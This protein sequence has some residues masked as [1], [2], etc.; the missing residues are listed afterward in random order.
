M[1]DASAFGEH[2]VA[3]QVGGVEDTCQPHEAR[4]DSSNT[5]SWTSQEAQDKGDKVEDRGTRI[6]EG[7]IESNAPLSTVG[8]AP[9]GQA[10]HNRTQRSEE[11][12]DYSYEGSIRCPGGVSDQPD[13]VK[14]GGKHP[15]RNGHIGYDRVQGMAEPGPIEQALEA[16]GRFP[17]RANDNP[18]PML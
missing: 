14:D 8:I 15:G 16:A 3:A 10:G 12:Y 5:I 9:I 1:V 6:E 11:A 2:H 18:Y 4:N 7:M 17:L 13:D